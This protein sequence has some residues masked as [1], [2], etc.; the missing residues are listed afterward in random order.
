MVRRNK[1]FERPMDFAAPDFTCRHFGLRED[2]GIP[3][4]FPWRYGRARED[5]ILIT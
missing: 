3:Q 1:P 4:C 5:A 2:L